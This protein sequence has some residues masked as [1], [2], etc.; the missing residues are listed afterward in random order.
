MALNRAAIVSV[1]GGKP[2]S[3]SDITEFR[4]GKRGEEEKWDKKA[5]Y[6]KIPSG[7]KGVGDSGYAGEPSKIVITRKEHSKAFKKFLARAKARQETMHTILKSYNIL[8]QRFRHGKGG[9]QDKIDL[10]R[11]VVEAIC[12]ITQYHYENGHP[13]F[14]M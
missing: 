6:F 13:P 2:A 11:S 3:T 8:G 14:S 12:V 4:G 9:T 10:H 5:L 1:N 7:K